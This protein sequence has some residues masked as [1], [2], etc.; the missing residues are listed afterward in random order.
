VFSSEVAPGSLSQK[1]R[2]NKNGDPAQLTRLRI[3]PNSGTS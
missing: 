3:Q 2:E 1:T